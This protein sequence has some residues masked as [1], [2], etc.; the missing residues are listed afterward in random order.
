M[1]QMLAKES[2][3]EADIVIPVPDSGMAA[4]LGFSEESGI[5]FEQGLIR[6]HYVGRTFIEPKQSI[7]NFGV[8]LKLNPSWKVL[9]D[10]RVIVIDD[11]LVRGTTSKKIVENIK[12]AGAKEVHFRV[13]SPPIKHSCKYGVDT[14]TEEELIANEK[15]L[16]E[17]AEYIGVNTL[18]YLSLEGLVKAVGDSDSY[19][20]A[21]FNGTY[22]VK[23]D[24]LG[25]SLQLRFEGL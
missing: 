7:R 3:I 14:P 11:S 9:K 13:S 10:K 12:R 8:M 23:F 24:D 22:P 21:C 5:P 18:A 17:I 19:C 20:T 16:D 1:G 2:M 15:N 6:S 25:K 4:A